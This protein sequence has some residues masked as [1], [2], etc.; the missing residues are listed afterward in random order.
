MVI[1][2]S[3]TNSDFLAEVYGDLD[4][5]QHG[6]VCHFQAD[7]SNAP[8]TVWAGRLY[9][10]TPQQALL[11]DRCADDNTYFCTSVLTATEDG[12]IA[13]IKAAFVRL[14]VLVLDDVQLQDLQGY[15]YAIQT[16][17]GK[18][19]VGILIDSDD[20]DAQDRRLVDLLMQALATRGYIKADKSG[21]N[22]VRYVRLPR[23]R[24]TK[25]RAAGEWQV[26]LESWTPQIRWSLEDACAAIGINLD[27]LRAASTVETTRSASSPGPSSQGV[28]AGE[29]IAGL[30]G[31][32]A[33]R[34]YHDNITRLA[35]SLVSNG[36]FPGA[37]VEFLRDLMHQ[38]KPAGPEEEVRRWQA[39]YDEIPRAVKSAEQFAPEARQPKIT[40][41]LNLPKTQDG[42][43]DTSA[44]LMTLDQL[45]AKAG[46]IKW[47][48]KHMIP[49]NS[50]G[51]FF[52]AS[53]TYKSFIALDH[54]LHV[55]HGLQWMGKKTTQGRVVYMAAE[56]G[57]GIY[58]RVHA[59]HQQH[60]LPLTANFH[61]C[62]T[63]MVLSIDAHVDALASAIESLP[64][65]PRLVCIDTLSQ[66][67]EGD[68]N[69]ATDISAYL[70][71]INAKIRARFDCTV[72]VIHH[73]GHAATERPRGSSAIIA[74]V[75]FLV[76]VYK[77]EGTA[78]MAR[79]DVIKQKDGDRLANLTFKLNRVVLGH[80][81]DGEELSSLVSQHHD[82]G[83]QIIANGMAK[84][85]GHEQVLMGLVGQAGGQIL[86]RDL[87]H[88]FYNHLG[89]EAVRGGKKY[90]Q[91]TAKRAYLRAYANLKDKGLVSM[92]A[93]GSVTSMVV[94]PAPDD[95]AA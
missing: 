63:P 38:V 50:L 1:A 89:Q 12:E 60:N 20:V 72:V 14:A 73:S 95:A 71:L 56:G 22:A 44:L 65:P 79:L 82:M 83:G 17:P 27:H 9:K 2:T 76:G 47:Q 43:D 55:A 10:G 13:R 21:N 6:W 57:A 70:R 74:N 39:R 49:D 36:M 92:D 53:G 87:R 85:A 37:A 42:Q 90:V 11:I 30:T 3:M 46:Q 5:G 48:V 26:R 81:E 75:D 40:V 29:M 32:I 4:P 94:Q 7:P 8:P 18:H 28:H 33:E 16:S 67:F 84:L 19:Q 69:S 91:D 66:T 64:S 52:G 77:P 78:Q 86:D 23:G 58:R 41:N 34:A 59:W 24:N 31:P 61:V 35:A 88:A 68:E 62:I 54:G 93:A 25:P 15:S 45:Q 51:M 80:D